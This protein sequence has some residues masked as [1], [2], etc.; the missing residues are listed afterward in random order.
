[1]LSYGLTREFPFA[2]DTVITELPKELKKKG[3]EILSI[4]HLDHTFNDL[5]DIDFR[6]YS[7]FSVTIV[8]LAYKALVR[9]E[10]FGVALPC[11]IAVY[12]K[13]GETVISTIKPS[14]FMHV[15]G[16]QDLNNGAAVLERKLQNVLDAFERKRS[17]IERSR[18]QKRTAFEKAVA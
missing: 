12:E 7:I 6:R 9:E 1:M 5:M 15:I 4:C 17:K 11:N 13:R 14:A 2:F 18:I 10:N 3:F 16:N 8:P